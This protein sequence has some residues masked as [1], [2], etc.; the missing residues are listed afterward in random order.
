MV[1]PE[2]FEDSGGNSNVQELGDEMIVSEKTE[3]AETVELEVHECI[4]EMTDL[5]KQSSDKRKTLTTSEIQNFFRSVKE[6][7]QST[8]EGLKLSQCV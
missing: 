7:S 2:G 4:R 5:L 3:N 1:Y 6:I 8:K